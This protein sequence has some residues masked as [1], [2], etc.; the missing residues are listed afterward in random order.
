MTREE[1]RLYWI[2]AAIGL[3]TAIAH[4]GKVMAQSEDWQTGKTKRCEE[5]ARTAEVVWGT[6]WEQGFAWDQIVV[7]EHA[8]WIKTLAM[9][10]TG[11]RKELHSHVMNVCMGAEA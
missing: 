7:D 10:H 6:H 5:K 3:V 8:E 1:K 11:T 2:V 9:Q 4:G